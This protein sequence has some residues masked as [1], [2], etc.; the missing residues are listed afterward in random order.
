MLE[1]TLDQRRV[2]DALVENRGVEEGDGWHDSPGGE[3][4][5]D[6]LRGEQVLDISHGGGEFKA[7]AQEV[8]GDFWESDRKTQ[9][10][11]RADHR[12]RRDRVLRRVEAF[13]SQIGELTDAYLK[14]SHNRSMKRSQGIFNELQ[15]EEF[16]VYLMCIASIGAENVSICIL[17]SDIFVASALVRRGVV[18][19]S[20]ISPTVAISIDAL[21]LYR[22]AHLRSPH[23]SIQAFVK[24]ICDLHGVEFHRYLSRQF[25]IAYDVYLQILNAVDALV[26]EAIQRN[27]KDWRLKHA[28]PACTY[29]LEGEGSLT[30]SMLYAMDGNDSL[31]RILRRLVVDDD[32]DDIGPSSELATSQCISGD[33]Y[34]SR[35]YVNQ[36][37]NSAVI[38]TEKNESNGANEENPC[39]GRWKNMD[40]EKTKKMWGV[41]DETG[42][43]LAVCRHGFSL[44]IA[45]MVQSGELAK[46]ALAVVSKMI[47][48]FGSDLGG[49]YDIGC[50][51]STTLA[52]SSVGLR[53]LENHHTCLVPAFHGHAHKRLCQLLHL[54][55]YIKGL[56]LE[57]LETCERT[58]SKSNALASAL[59]YSSIFH[60]QQGIAT[61]FEHN[62]NFE[63]YQNL[64]NFL[65]NNY[66]QAL[67]ILYDGQNTLPQLMHELGITSE[68]V[69]EQWL[70]EEKVYL[71]SLRSE[72]EEETLQMEYLQK[73]V[74][75]MSSK[76]NLDANQAAWITST[77]QN[78][79]FG[80]AD[81]S[82]TRK[83]ETARRHAQ[84]IY[85]NDLKVV[86]LL[87]ARLELTR[88]WVPGDAEWEHA[89]TL[90]ANRKYQ[91]ALDTL[92]GLVVARI[93]ELTKMNR[94][95][96]GYK[97]RKHIAKALQTRSA[98]IRTA[99]DR[100]NA[101]AQAMTPPRRQ[102]NW[103]EV[104][105]YAF[106]ADF[107][108]LRDARQ[109]VADRPWAT[110]SARRA[111]DLYYKMCRAKEE[112]E[113]LNI[114]T[115]RLAT[116]IR[117]EESYLRACEA[118]LASSHPE[119]AH[120]VQRHRNV[121]DRFNARHL[122]RIN[123]IFKL[124]GFSGTIAPGVS[125]QTG[126]GE[127]AS[128]PTVCVPMHVMTDKETT[129]FEAFGAHR[130]PQ[131]THEDLDDEEQ[132][133][134]DAEEISLALQDVLR[135]SADA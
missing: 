110:P 31:K 107:D 89:A 20:P 81:I 49:G 54:A 18:P 67:N 108:L 85:D 101:A 117:D 15:S 7:L 125:T 61:Y 2:L 24:T 30:F 21:E 19:C 42:I 4:I 109:N 96:T 106:L 86:Q 40:D 22:V 27:S 3:Y 130:E 62:D 88:R 47:D 36:F 14:W 75:L 133:D 41:Y 134:Y 8:M 1:L 52:N 105:E 111:L 64:S 119:V 129:R 112:I 38:P 23:L 70:E 11:R 98:A 26:A 13:N 66:K 132:A 135:V 53:A 79:S 56:G 122:K 55:L 63:V 43:F 104:V 84:E 6:V 34:L 102:L 92:E 123:D 12:T 46:Y 78:P 114:E 99:L 69:F 127:S 71:Q 57:D 124:P 94:S 97:M 74:N 37:E 50:Q 29:T 113:R 39:A 83:N 116:Y 93:F 73:L 45:D 25:S 95:G 33:R 76:A 44:V 100:Y 103:E 48:T 68:A 5:E 32:T 9:S 59:R 28:C 10:T 91:R 128:T 51:F 17:P 118:Q 80:S 77:P 60:R 72:P 115:R 58:F 65:Y 82:R 90:V 120:Q 16:R 35:D 87:E 131:E 126:P 121:R